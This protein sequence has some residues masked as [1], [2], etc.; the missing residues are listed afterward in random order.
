MRTSP[1]SP[2]TP[3]RTTGSPPT[4]RSPP[5]TKSYRTASTISPPKYGST[6]YVPEIYP[7]YQDAIFGLFAAYA[8]LVN[9][10]IQYLASADPR[11]KGETAGAHRLRIRRFATDH[12]RAILPAATLTNVGLT[13]NAR[14]LEHIISKLLSTPIH[15]VVK[16]GE[17]LSAQA[18]TVVPT[19]IKYAR[20][21][22]HLA[23]RNHRRDIASTTRIPADRIPPSAKL[24]DPDPIAVQKVVAA[25]LFNNTDASYSEAWQRAT[26]M[27]PR[28]RQTILDEAT[29]QIGPHD[30]APRE[31]EAAQFTFEFLMD[32][33]AL[34]EFKRHRM[35]TAHT[36]YLTIRNG[37]SIPPLIT[38]AGLAGNLHP[39]PSTRPNRPSCS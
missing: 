11:Q 38:E 26:S 19:L 15:E 1:G 20:K 34:R 16:L 4:R 28:N 31:F 21:N 36:K 5:V 18:Q 29:D 14:T 37:Y 7:A 39:K 8:D 17:E 35:Q 9:R 32:Y 30:P 25:L 33:G 24:V 2:V 6:P 10:S 13:A 27:E 3:W 23:H 12:C 22:P